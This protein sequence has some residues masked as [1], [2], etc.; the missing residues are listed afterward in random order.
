MSR[1]WR[2]PK[3]NLTRGQIAR[4]PDALQRPNGE[5]NTDL[6][7]DCNRYTRDAIAKAASFSN[8]WRFEN[9]ALNDKRFHHHKIRDDDGRLLTYCT[10]ADSA[11]AWGAWA[12][13]DNEARR[14]ANLRKGPTRFDLDFCDD[15]PKPKRIKRGK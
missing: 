8:P 12:R 13:A 2:D 14:L 6:L 1:W 11:A 10:H 15:Q 5:L 9:Q 7:P 4:L 3:S